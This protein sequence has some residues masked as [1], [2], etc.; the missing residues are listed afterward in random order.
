[1]KR[2]L[3]LACATAL[4]VAPVH[5]QTADETAIR[6]RLAAYAQSRSADGA[7]QAQFYAVDADE[8]R[9][10]NRR[11]LRGRPEIA[12]DLDRARAGQF[13]LHIE[14]VTMLSSDLAL[15]DTE[16]SST[17]DPGPTGHASYLMANRDGVW[18]IKSARISRYPEIRPS[19]VAAAMTEVRAANE[20]LLAA[21]GAGDRTGYARLVGDDLQ[22][23]SPES[24]RVLSKAERVASLAPSNSARTFS[25]VHVQMYGATAIV[26]FRSEWTAG[27]ERRAERVQR[28]FVKRGGQW[29]LVSHAATPMGPGAR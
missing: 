19:G 25:D 22:W 4:S 27:G 13:R 20:A 26:V 23:I 24:G 11:M 12:A 10:A 28:A 1:M 9:D 15:A 7:T 2:C 18:L 14:S 8:W 17:D 5:G 16:F 21:A 3:L 29:Q 6:A